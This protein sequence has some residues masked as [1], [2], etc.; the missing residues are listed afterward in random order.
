MWQA[1]DSSRHVVLLDQLVGRASA[2][3]QHSRRLRHREHERKR[4]ERR[5]RRVL[6]RNLLC[7]PGRSRFTLKSDSSGAGRS[8]SDH[9]K[10]AAVAHLSGRVHGHCPSLGC[11]RSEPLFCV[12]AVLADGARAEAIELSQFVVRIAVDPVEDHEPRSASR[13]DATPHGLV[14][15]RE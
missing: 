1:S 6:R 9:L 11:E 8:R 13:H 3:A 10:G 4:L 12:P 7:A 15:K 5:E 14:N 2:D